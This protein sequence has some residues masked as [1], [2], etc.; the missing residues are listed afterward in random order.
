[1]EKHWHLTTPWA[2]AMGPC[3]KEFKGKPEGI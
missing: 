3:Y 2:D 1:M